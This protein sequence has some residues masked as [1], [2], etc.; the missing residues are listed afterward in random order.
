MTKTTRSQKREIWAATS[1]LC[2]ILSSAP[3]LANAQ[4]QTTTPTPPSAPASEVVIVRGARPIQESDRA[5]LLIQRASSSLVSV[6]SADEAGRLADQNIAQ[7][8]SR[9]AGIAVERDQGQARYVNLRGQPRRWVN[10]SIDGLN[11]V[12]PE[13]RDTRFDNIPSAIASQVIVNKAITPDM[14]GDTV[15][16][17]INIRTRS[18]FDYRSNTLRGDVQIGHVEV[19][20]GREIDASLVGSARLFDGKLGIL[21]QASFYEREMITDN[22]ETDPYLRPGG[23]LQGATAPSGV[24][25]RAGSETRRW[26]REFENKPYRLTRGNISGSLRVDYR[27]TENDL[28]FGQSVFTQ[29]TDDELRNNYIFRFDQGAT[30]TPATACPL[31]TAPQT[32]SG[33]YDICNGNQPNKGTVFGTQIRAN[34]R[35]GQTKEYMFTNTIGGDHERDAWKVAWR[36][37]FTETEDGRDASGT[38]NFISPTDI[39]RRPT[40][41]YDFTDVSNNTVRLFNTVVANGV[42]SRGPAQTSIDAFPLDFVD[43]VSTEGG[44]ITS[45]YTGKIDVTHSM[46]FG[47]VEADIKVGLLYTTREKKSRDVQ[48]RATAASVA[49]AGLAPITYDSIAINDPFL[50]A[51]PL[52]Y[53]FRY[54]SLAATQDLMT[55]LKARGAAVQID[56]TGVYYRVNEDITAGYAMATF[57]PAWGSVV[58]GARVEQTE[59]TGEAFVTIGGVPRLTSVSSSETAIYPS[60]HVNYDIDDTQKLRF[61]LTTGASRPDFD[62]LAPNFAISDTARTIS[63]GNPLAKPERALGYDVYYENYI[64]PQGYLQVGIF[65]KYLQDVLFQQAGIFGLDTLDSNGIDRSDYTFTTFRNGGSGYIF[66]I[67]VAYNQFAEQLVQSLGGPKWMEG[68]GVRLSATASESKINIPAIDTAPYRSTSLPGASDL[69]YNASLVYEKY[70]LSARLAY[71]FRTKFLQS[72][73]AYASVNGALVPDGNGDIYWNDTDDLSLSLRYE[74]SE[75]LELTFDAVNLIDSP[76]RRFADSKLNPIEYETFGARY[77]AGVRFKF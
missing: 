5:A 59:N 27:L 37:N 28:I 8:L 55:E 3:S 66:G 39:T 61:G 54:Y 45:A 32:T 68:F 18:A 30:N 48:F 77:L 12:S 71:Q 69:V 56:T 2:L 36:L 4:S 16:G 73:G 38:P 19:G 26:A 34:F 10:V 33:A 25:R 53:T 29:F 14:G 15:S 6:L 11:I 42:R 17:N 31:V 65:G 46:M 62:E 51:T 50:G 13:G 1:A 47:G 22:W 20:D 41:D 70:G 67:E 75:R 52:G 74:L 44:D 43:I 63:G 72:V 76:G 64:Q 40:V 35:S 7:A 9:V 58:L 21:A 60:L 57:K 49:A 23:T 24:D